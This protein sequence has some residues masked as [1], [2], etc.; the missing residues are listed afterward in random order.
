MLNLLFALPAYYRQANTTLN[1]N[2]LEMFFSNV[3]YTC[4]YSLFSSL[5]PAAIL[6]KDMLEMSVNH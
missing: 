6:Y 3:T 1:R 5:N 2:E 4:L